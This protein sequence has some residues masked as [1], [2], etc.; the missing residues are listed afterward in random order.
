LELRTPQT[1]SPASTAVVE[2]LRAAGV[3][4]PGPDRYLAPEI[5]AAYQVTRSGDVRRAAETV[6]GPLA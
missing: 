1:P 6:T 2:A 4:G 3:A 5:E